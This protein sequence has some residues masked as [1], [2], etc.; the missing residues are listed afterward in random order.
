MNLGGDSKRAAFQDG[1][2]QLADMARQRASLGDL[3]LKSALTAGCALRGLSHMLTM[4]AF[5]RHES[6]FA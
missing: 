3:A 4:A 6:L 1:V 2:Q 5:E